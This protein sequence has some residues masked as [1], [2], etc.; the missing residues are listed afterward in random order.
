[1]IAVTEASFARHVL[2][3]ELP[4]LV[5]FGTRACPGWRAMRPALELLSERH[6]GRLVIATLRFDNAPLLAEQYWIGVSPTLVAFEHGDPQGQ[7]VGFLPAGLLE[8]L[9]EDML[10]GK[11]TGGQLWSPVEERFE[12][13]VLIPLLAGWGLGVERQVTCALPARNRAQRGRIDLLVRAGPDGAPLTLI[14][15]KRQ[16]R[17][18]AELWQAAQQAAAY[19][20][21][22]DLPSFV[23]AAPRGLWIYRRDG[24]GIRCVRHLTSLEL[25][26]G[27]EELRRLVA[28]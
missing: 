6:R 18:D 26:Q 21:S 3:A 7:A 16:I 27:P 25:H 23:V 22:L 8:L 2:R 28:G 10:A 9:A 12:D 17:S 14:E 4:A 1:M 13:A 24:E 5:C 20:A 15:S 11:V 19:A